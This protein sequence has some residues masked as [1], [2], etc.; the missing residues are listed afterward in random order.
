MVSAMRTVLLLALIVLVVSVLPAQ[1]I[2]YLYEVTGSLTMAGATASEELDF[3]FLFAYQYSEQS[4]LYV[5]SVRGSHVT[6]TG[7]LAPFKVGYVGF[8]YIDFTN[9]VV[10]N[11]ADRFTI[12]G[13]NP[14]DGYGFFTTTPWITPEFGNY[15]DLFSL[16]DRGLSGGRIPAGVR[17]GPRR[18]RGHTH[19]TRTRREERHAHPRADDA[20]AGRRGTRRIGRSETTATRLA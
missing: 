14:G 20:A 16:R 17:L 10:L 15:A 18:D 1:A 13:R 6:S 19:R 4:N 5:P 9:N 8:N 2:S 7:P 11:D 12:F 3:R